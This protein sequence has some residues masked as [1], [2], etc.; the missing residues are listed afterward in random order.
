M[1]P[2]LRETASG[3]SDEQ[4]WLEGSDDNWFALLKTPDFYRDFW[5]KHGA[6]VLQGW[7]AEH[8]GTPPLRWW[9]H[10]APFCLAD[11]PIVLAYPH[12]APQL[13]GKLGAPRRRLGGTG[14][15]MYFLL[16][17]VPRWI[18][19]IPQGWVTAEDKRWH[20]WK[21]RPCT[22]FDPGDPPLFESQAAY[23]DRHG[24]L[25]PAERKRLT[26]ADFAPEAATLDNRW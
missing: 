7:I 22:A 11:E 3:S 4:A 26:E 19:G 12:L 25:R 13:V 17:G 20:P 16:G 14:D 5:L 18:F 21:D 24:L 9:Q 8:P 15:E 23:L 10:Q 2:K 1:P 6:P